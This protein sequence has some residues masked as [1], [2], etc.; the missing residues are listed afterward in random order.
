MEVFAGWAQGYAL[1]LGLEEENLV[2]WYKLRRI[3]YSH[4]LVDAHVAVALTQPRQISLHSRW[5]YGAHSV[6]RLSLGAQDM[7]ARIDGKEEFC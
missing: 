1:D 3:L 4:D 6:L 5:V 2:F 7:F